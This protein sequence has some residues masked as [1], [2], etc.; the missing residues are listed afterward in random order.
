[1]T[2]SFEERDPRTPA[3]TAVAEPGAEDVALNAGSADRTARSGEHSWRHV[4]HDLGTRSAIVWIWIALIIAYSL[5][6]PSSFFRVGTFQT[7]FSSQQ[8]LVFLTLGLLCTMCVGEYVDLSIASVLGLSATMIPVLVVNDHWNVAIASVVA[9]AAAGLAGAFNGYLV[10]YL[11]VDVII[12]T[13][14]SGTFI[15]GLT[16]WMSHLGEVVGLSSSFASIDLKSILGLPIS[17]YYGLVLILLFAYVLECTPLGRRMRFVGA[18]REVARLSGIRVKRIRFGAFVMG[19]V[20]CGLGG[21]L[22]SAGIGGFDPNSSQTYLLPA[23]ATVSL[24]TAVIQ[25]GRFNPIGT[26]VAIYFLATGILG[27]ELLGAAGW[28]SDVFYGGSLVVAVTVATV[29]RRRLLLSH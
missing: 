15:L 3:E 20:F 5:L 17:F 24:G 22:A 23:F 21:L 18:N 6:E 27:L 9:V 16:L 29:L 7:I 19:G 8:A 13:L 10:V 2:T 1:M 28:V 26:F 14:G 4:A 25:P 12:V 11:G